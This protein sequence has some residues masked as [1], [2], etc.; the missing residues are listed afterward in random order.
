M[1][2]I[3]IDMKKL[4][5]LCCLIFAT[6]HPYAQ[7]VSSL[8]SKAN[9]FENNMNDLQAII[10]YREALTLD[11]ANQYLLCKCSELCSRIGARLDKD[12]VQQDDYF[13]AADLYARRALKI[14]PEN[15]DANFVMSLVMGQNAL[16]KGGKEKIDAVRG[17]KKYADLA[18]KYNPGNYKAWFVLGK[19]YYEINSLNYFERTAV[20][21]F[22][23]ALPPATLEDALKCFERVKTINPGFVLNYLSLAKVYKKQDNDIRA[24]EYL[25]VMVNLPDKTQDDE[26]YKKEA[27]ELLKKW[28]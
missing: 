21:V 1:M 3:L 24:K 11:P 10:F 13:A 7:D 28:D 16:R 25:M 2:Y 22:F 8:I 12:K 20:K 19:W 26:N 18:I 17:I 9:A 15:S 4:L 5:F 27:R 6:G 23:G 14:N